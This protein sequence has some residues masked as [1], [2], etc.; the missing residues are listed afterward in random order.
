MLD[1]V[2][3]A[4]IMRHYKSFKSINQEK[5]VTKF[6]HVLAFEMHRITKSFKNT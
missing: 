4:V 6:C 1:I 3:S 2:R 5:T